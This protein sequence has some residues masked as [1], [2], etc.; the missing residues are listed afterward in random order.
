[1]AAARRRSVLVAMLVLSVALA[2]SACGEQSHPTVANA[3]NDG[4][5]VDAGPITYQLQISRVLNPYDTEDSGYLAGVPGSTSLP[6]EEMW[7]GVFLWAKNQTHA[8]ATTSDSFVITDT[9]G[10]RYYPVKLNAEL[11]PYAWTAMSLKPLDTEPIPDSTAYWGPTQG[12]LLLFR[13]NMD[14]YSN[15]P[16]VLSIYAEG[17]AH[18]SLISLDL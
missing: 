12:G 2:V 4:G 14:V 3:N 16:L 9:Q 11:N 15:R 18:P 8:A 10:N 1:M 6:P 17:Q 5:Y 13:L 7:Y